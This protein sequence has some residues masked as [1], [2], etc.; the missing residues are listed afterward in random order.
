MSNQNIQSPYTYK[1]YFNNQLVEIINCPYKINIYQTSNHQKSKSNDFT[2]TIYSCELDA[3]LNS[4][5]K[6][7]ILYDKSFIQA[8]L[9]KY[10][11]VN[12]I[13]IN[14]IQHISNKPNQFDITLNQNE[15]II[16]LP[17]QGKYNVWKVGNKNTIENIEQQWI[18]SVNDDIKLSNRID[19]VHSVIHTILIIQ[20]LSI[21]IQLIFKFFN[22]RKAN[23]TNIQL[24]EQSSYA[25]KSDNENYRKID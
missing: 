18:N 19:A 21:V 8:S 22:K 24:E 2:N 6:M 5:T 23:N 3:Q 17:I 20:I 16:K 9:M 1:F 15:H 14:D 7:E 4:E 11:Q 13:G 12:K 10:F 25:S